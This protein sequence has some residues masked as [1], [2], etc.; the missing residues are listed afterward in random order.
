[1]RQNVSKEPPWVRWYVGAME[2]VLGQAWMTL[3]IWKVFV[4]L[5]RGLRTDNRS[6]VTQRMICQRTGIAQPNISEALHVLMREGIIDQDRR[7]GP[8]Y[9]SISYCYRGDRTQRPFR[10]KEE[11]RRRRDKEGEGG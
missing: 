7:G 10:Q 8:Y 1:M 4:C 6:T 2:V 3:T 9:I 11:R 5:L